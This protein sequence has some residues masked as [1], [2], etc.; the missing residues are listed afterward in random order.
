MREP[1]IITDD[2]LNQ[3]VPSDKIPQRLATATILLIP[4]QD[5]VVIFNDRPDTWGTWFPFYDDKTQFVHD[6]VF[7]PGTYGDLIRQQQADFNEHAPD[8]KERI[9][10]LLNRLKELYGVTA[11]AKSLSSLKPYYKLQ[12]SATA[13]IWT[14]YQVEYF[15]AYNIDDIQ[16][17]FSTNAAIKKGI[18]SF[19]HNPSEPLEDIPLTDSLVHL[20]ETPAAIESVKSF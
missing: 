10:R 4:A 1:I 8:E 2:L 20:L 14:L 16:K 9:M 6:M 11:T 17:I 18:L 15:V 7:E 13:K 3:P 5:G 12:F 19:D